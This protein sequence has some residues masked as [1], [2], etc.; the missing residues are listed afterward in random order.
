MGISSKGSGG[1]LIDNDEVCPYARIPV[2][3]QGILGEVVLHVL[4]YG[5]SLMIHAIKKQVTIKAGGSIQIYVPEFKEGTFAEV[6]VLESSEQ[7]PKRSM[8][9]LIGK[10]RGGFRLLKRLIHLLQMSGLHGD[11]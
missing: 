11:N 6:I 7:V 3:G 1:D 9:N 4:L 5:E 8:I 2:P 10:G